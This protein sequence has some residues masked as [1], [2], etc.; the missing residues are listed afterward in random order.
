M[1]C[2]GHKH[3]WANIEEKY[4][5]KGHPQ[6]IFTGLFGNFEGIPK[7]YN[8]GSAPLPSD[9]STVSDLYLVSRTRKLVNSAAHGCDLTGNSNHKRR[10]N[11]VGFSP[12]I[13]RSKVKY[14]FRPTQHSNSITGLSTSTNKK[15]K[16]SYFVIEL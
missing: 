11:L 8:F 7:H 6:K 1:F 3:I 13:P 2:P 5:T 10:F 9:T 14:L 15:I 12:N 4:P 16:N